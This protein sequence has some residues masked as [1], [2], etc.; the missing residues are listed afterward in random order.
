M[1]CF[2]ALGTVLLLLVCLLALAGESLLGI[3]LIFCRCFFR[4]LFR[5]S[6]RVMGGG[7]RFRSSGVGVFVED[8]GIMLAHA[9]SC[10]MSSSSSSSCSWSF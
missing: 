5:L 4:I 6:V 2:L 1:N 9:L 10:S 7:R 3:T 8:R